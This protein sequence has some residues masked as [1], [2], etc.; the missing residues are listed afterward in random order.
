[1]YLAMA[2]SSCVLY[3]TRPVTVSGRAV[4]DGSGAPLANHEIELWTFKPPLL[5]FWMGAYVKQ[6]TVLTDANGFF[7][8]TA[9]VP[10][11]PPFDLR[12]HNAGTVLG[13][14]IVNLRPATTL[15]D[16]TIVHKVE[17]PDQ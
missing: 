2:T 15:T 3:A 16:V 7:K 9:K 10:S 6:S 14:G 13:G 8:L 1:V 5:P 11:D 4:I 17:L 12:T